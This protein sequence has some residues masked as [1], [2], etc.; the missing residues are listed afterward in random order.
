MWPTIRNALGDNSRKSRKRKGQ[1]QSPLRKSLQVETLEVRSLMAVLFVGD[2]TR[3]YGQSQAVANDQQTYAVSPS[4]V[5]MASTGKSMVVYSG[6]NQ[7][8]VGSGN[9]DV[10]LQIVN[11]DGSLSTNL[12][13]NTTTA[14][15]QTFGNVAV[16]PTGAGNYV[17]V[18]SGRGDQTGQL[19]ANGI[20]M[21][22]FNASNA[23]SGSETLV[24]TS[25]NPNIIQSRP[26]VAMDEDG[27]YVVAWVD[28]RT[29]N[30]EFRRNIYLRHF[31]AGGVPINN[32]VENN[33]TERV[34]SATAQDQRHVSVAMGADGNYLVVWSEFVGGLYRAFG[35]YFTPTN[36]TAPFPLSDAGLVRNQFYPT[37]A[38]D[39]SGDF[40]VTWTETLQG[41][42]IPDLT[43]TATDV[44]VRRFSAPVFGSAPIPKADPT[45]STAAL[46]VPNSDFSGGA[47]RFSRVAVDRTTGDYV[48]VWD[49]VGPTTSK[50][51]TTSNDPSQVP[52][53]SA[54]TGGG[55]FGERFRDNGAPI[56]ATA[57]NPTGGL[58]RANTTT[59]GAQRISG[60]AVRAETTSTANAS[61]VI[62]AWSGNGIQPNQADTQGVFFQRFQRDTTNFQYALNGTN[63]IDYSVRNLTPVLLAPDATVND[64][65]AIEYNGLVLNVLLSTEG[66]GTDGLGLPAVEFLSIRNQGV[67][68]GQIGVN[69]NNITF[70]GVQIATFAFA[71]DPADPLQ[72]I[73]TVTFNQAVMNTTGFRNTAVQAVLRNVQY[74]HNLPRTTQPLLPERFTAWT[75]TLIDNRDSTTLTKSIRFTESGGGGG[76]GPIFRHR[77]FCDCPLPSVRY[78]TSLYNV[79]L[80]R[81]GSDAEI[82]ALAGA[83]RNGYPPQN[84]VANFVTSPEYRRWLIAD[85]VNGFYPRY[86]GRQADEAGIQF[87]LN[88][89]AN[90]VSEQQVL[91]G[92][93]G[94]QE[95]FVTKGGST[96][97]GY[98]TAL[99]SELLLRT[100]PPSTAELNYY[101][102]QLNAGRPRAD[103]AYGFIYSTEYETQLV[104]EWFFHYL[105]DSN[106]NT[107]YVGRAMAALNVRN[108]W[109][110]A[111]TYILT[112]TMAIPRPLV[113]G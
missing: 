106:P 108:S 16:N 11:P 100:D 107:F 104:N 60:V 112:T 80:E 14:G 37:A 75:F 91:A 10:L 43:D 72:R 36:I 59:P 68:A 65:N 25:T 88:A 92:I 82:N 61:N 19:D 2:E 54:A 40:I 8:E 55:V 50:R 74:Q 49:G 1:H 32:A 58:F 76:E 70:G 6:P 29:E 98:V 47:Q 39:D 99:Y 42:D 28:E 18:W 85:P 57:G 33:T 34:L 101:V 89:M 105:D 30:G 87:W 3:A 81:E 35:R 93:V 46:V 31:T 103:I 7:N 44:F 12:T 73:L 64:A 24:N 84:A 41:F 69:G 26:T 97:A 90:G 52:A 109:L 113:L 15:D 96:N 66:I 23:R 79:L 110:D 51:T 83:L 17:V 48:I 22:R 62:V 4:P 5:A 86:L 38:I 53:D 111:Q 71:V 9:N 27:N 95:F 63:P 56:G 20:F 67:L 21:Q 94:S 13:V 77:G 102:N 78:A 45:G